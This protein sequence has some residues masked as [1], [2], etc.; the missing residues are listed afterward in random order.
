MIYK[1]TPYIIAGALIILFFPIIYVME[2]N[3]IQFYA[4]FLEELLGRFIPILISGLFSYA[5]YNPILMG[6]MSGSLFGFLEIL[7]KTYRIGKF[8]IYMFVPFF[9]VHMVNAIIQSLLIKRGLEENKS[10]IVVSIAITSLWH[11]MY[12]SIFYVV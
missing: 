7:I 2:L 11:W 6:I 3:T 10:L 4:P 9:A 8:S 12:N 5:M 1:R